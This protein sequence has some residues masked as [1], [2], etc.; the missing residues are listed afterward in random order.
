[1]APK[2]SVIV[3]IYNAEKYLAEC[4]ESV[5]C[6]RFTDIELLLVND[7]S[8]D[9][10]GSICDYYSFSDP[11]VRVFHKENTGVSDTRNKAL[12]LA[13]G[14]YVIFLDADDYWIDV[15]F[16]EKFYNLAVKDDLDIIRGEYK[17]VTFSGVS[18]SEF[19]IP[20]LRTKVIG[21]VISSDSFLENVILGEYFLVLSLIKRKSIDDI[22]FNT[23]RI[24]LED[25]EFY[26]TLLIKNL[27]CA[28]FPILFYAYRKHND[29]VTIKPNPKKLQDAFDF[30]SLCYR[31][32]KE[33][34]NIR[35][36]ECLVAE[37]IKNYKFDLKSI[38]ES[39]RTFSEIK[40][41]SVKYNLSQKRKETLDAIDI[42]SKVLRN[43]ICILPVMSI[44]SYYR[45]IYY[46]RKYA[47]SLKSQLS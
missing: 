18:I 13:Q 22:R 45:V 41:L 5:L 29:A 4:I 37:G 15:T 28:Y 32:A 21:N 6:Q 33:T 44:M 24:F 14:D 46:F 43:L 11:R 30:S 19:K 38:A 40:Q 25:A 17:Y 16:L 35:L 8:T 47:R 36:K 23:S 3:P 26:L 12:D 20:D 7:G 9:G 2:I 39:N 42:S 10:S 31:L 34:N 27:R 1:M